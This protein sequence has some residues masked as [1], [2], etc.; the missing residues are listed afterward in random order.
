MN[1]GLHAGSL[2]VLNVGAG[3]VRVEFSDDEIANDKTIAMIE[4]M[5]QH[6]Y[7]V[8]VESDGDWLRVTRI[9]R[10]QREYVLRQNRRI[11]L[12]GTQAKVEQAETPAK[13]TKAKREKRAPVRSSRAVGVARSAGGCAPR[14]PAHLL[15]LARAEVR[16]RDGRDARD[17][18]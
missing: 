13:A 16:A 18:R 14:S 7:A 11:A 10:E 1:A 9:D 3:D 8:L 4:D 15:A 6:G 2:A 5:L 17:A 12:P